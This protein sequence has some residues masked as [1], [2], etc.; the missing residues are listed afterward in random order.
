MKLTVLVAAVLLTAAVSGAQTDPGIQAAQQAAQQAQQAN[1]RAIADLQHFSD[2]NALANAQMQA[3]MSHGNTPFIA[4]ALSPKI[5]IKSGSYTSPITV[6]LTS[7]TRGSI[8]YYTTDG[9]TPTTASTRYTGPITIDS[10]TTLRAIA[11]SAYGARSLVT[12]AVYT[13]PASP[14]PAAAMPLAAKPGQPIPVRL[15]FAKDVSSKTA[16]IGDRIPLTLADDLVVNGAAIARKGASAFVT[17]IQVDKTGAAGAPGNLEFQIDPLQTDSGV[18]KLR[19]S[20]SLEG[21]AAP[22][23]GAVLIPLVGALTLLHHGH[24]AVIKAGTPFTAYLDPAGV[25]DSVKNNR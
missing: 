17:I 16:E 2:Q 24:D 19:G 12:S 5:S 4:G 13:F 23:N 20:A 10:T 1:E 21:Q 8:M 6:K 22:P 11:V 3:A 14:A 7:R 15:L 25:S 9:W 18:L